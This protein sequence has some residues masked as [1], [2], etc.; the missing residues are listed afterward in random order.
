VIDVTGLTT[1]TER[2]IIYSFIEQST[3]CSTQY[4]YS[5]QTDA[6]QQQRPRSKKVSG[7]GDG[8]QQV[9]IFRQTDA[10]EEIMGVENLNQS[11]P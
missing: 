1:V 5:S 8:W 3:H 7:R 10:A 11:C 9:A 2:T 6:S 4:Q